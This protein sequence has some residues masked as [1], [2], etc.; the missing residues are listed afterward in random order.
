MILMPIFEDLL[1]FKSLFDIIYFKHVYRE[2][3]RMVD[4][5][6]E[7]GTQLAFG[8]WYIT[9][10]ENGGHRGYYHRPFQEVLANYT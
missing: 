4:M 3:N 10:H 8:S 7:E 5:L 2:H 9:E 1:S 6:S